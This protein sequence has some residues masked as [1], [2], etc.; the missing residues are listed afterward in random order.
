MSGEER[1]SGSGG[2]PGPVEERSATEGF[3]AGGRGEARQVFPC[4]KMELRRVLGGAGC[5]A[6]NLIFCGV[7][8]CQAAGETLCSQ[9]SNPSFS[10]ISRFKLEDSFYFGIPCRVQN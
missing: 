10:A 1:D 7:A 8:L 3:G 2:G 5:G 4:P 9:S 6:E